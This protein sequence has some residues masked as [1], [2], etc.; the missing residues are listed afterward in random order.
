MHLGYYIS[1]TKSTIFP[2]QR[3]VHLGFTIDSRTQSYSL[4]DKYRLKFQTF[5]LELLQ[6]DTV[7]L[8]DL[9]RWVGKC[10]H[11]RLLFPANS[12]FT[13]HCRRLMSSLGEERIPLPPDARD[14]ILFWSFVDSMTAPVPFLLQQHASLS[15]YTDA[16]GFGWG[17]SVRL[18]SG[19]LILRDYWCSKLFSHDICVK[20]RLW[21][22]S[23]PFAHSSLLSVVVASTFSWT[24][25]AW[26]THGPAFVRDLPS[27]RAF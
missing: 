20:K 1:P 9:Q 2:V 14:E 26:C 12:L 23:S 21:P 11:L 16:S 25:W 24:I 13:L 7:C 15:L 17:A 6:R 3:M 8:N 22:F 5:R 18:P 27:S 19:P 10:N 4:T